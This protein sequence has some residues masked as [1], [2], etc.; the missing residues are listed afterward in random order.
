MIYK[1]SRIY[2][3]SE[4]AG[5]VNVSQQTV[6]N[7]IRKGI[8]VGYSSARHRVWLDYERA[9]KN[10]RIYGKHLNQFFNKIH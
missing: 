2:T 10:Y 3:T 4:V 8:V 5:M 7:W 9:G 1:D 6:Y